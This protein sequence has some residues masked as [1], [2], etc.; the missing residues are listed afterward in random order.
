MKNVT[1]F[2]SSMI[3]RGR[4]GCSVLPLYYHLVQHVCFYIV[5]YRTVCFFLMTGWIFVYLGIP[6]HCTLADTGKGQDMTDPLRR[7]D[8]WEAA[9]LMVWLLCLSLGGSFN[10]TSIHWVLSTGQ[11][12]AGDVKIN[13]TEFL[14]LSLPVETEKTDN[15]SAMEINAILEVGWDGMKYTEGTFSSFCDGDKGFFVATRP[16]VGLEVIPLQGESGEGRG[17]QRHTLHEEK[18]WPKVWKH[19][20]PLC[21]SN[22]SWGFGKSNRWGKDWREMGFWEAGL[23]KVMVAFTCWGA[24]RRRKIS[25]WGPCKLSSDFQSIITRGDLSLWF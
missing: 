11:I 14:S 7:C 1:L 21:V 25:E 3:L 12:W 5:S 16:K 2:P 10:S 23:G 20:W 19:G 9:W 13:K 17:V 18:P 24:W 8:Q 22:R 4:V 6:Q 15:S